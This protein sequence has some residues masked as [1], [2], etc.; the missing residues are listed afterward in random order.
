MHSRLTIQAADG[1]QSQDDTLGS[2]K[3]AFDLIFAWPQNSAN[4]AVKQWPAETLSRAEI[5][6]RYAMFGIQSLKSASPDDQSRATHQLQSSMTASDTRHLS[7]PSLFRIQVGRSWSPR[8]SLRQ[9]HMVHSAALRQVPE[10]SRRMAGGGGLL[11]GGG[12]EFR[13]YIVGAL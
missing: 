10:T 12:G 7:Q 5:V 4:A 6:H 2:R 8:Q 9:M 13:Y 11:I 1:D 3:N